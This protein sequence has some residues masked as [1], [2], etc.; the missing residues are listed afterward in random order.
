MKTLIFSTVLFFIIQTKEKK[1]GYYKYNTCND[2][3]T[4]TVFSTVEYN[5]NDTL[6]LNNK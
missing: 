2:T 1:D 5:V 4:Y 3:L 6:Y